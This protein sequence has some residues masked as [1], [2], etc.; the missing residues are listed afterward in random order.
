MMGHGGAAVVGATER[1]GRCWALVLCVLASALIGLLLAS[2]ASA[3]KVRLFEET[4]GSAAQPS[5]SIAE[6]LAVDPASGDLLVIDAGTSTLSR[7]NPDGTPANFSALGTNTI[8]GIGPGDETPQGGLG[9]GG[10]SEVQ[11]AVDDSGTATDGNI[12]LTQSFANVLDVFAPSGAY[13]GQLSAA[14]ATPFGFLC[15]VAVGPGGA[16]YVGDYSNGV[17]KFAP[18]ANPPLATDHTA[19]FTSVANPCAL[20]VGAGP[21]AGSLFATTYVGDVSKLDAT[22]GALQYVVS[23]GA[24]TTISLDPASGHLLAVQGQTVSEYDASGSEAL[25]VASF[26]A[27]REVL[28]LAIDGPSQDLYLARGGNP[29]L[30]TY[31]PVVTV[32]DASTAPAS[33]IGKTNATLN[34]TV[35]PDGV[36]LEECSF[37][38]GPT[39]AYGQSVPCAETVVEIG[40][41]SEALPVHA[42]LGG[43]G[44]G[45]VYH[46][47]LVARNANGTAHGAD[48]SFKTL[49]PPAIEEQWVHS[50]FLAEA[51]LKGS[52]NPEG[53]PTSFHIEYGTDTT[54]GQST[55]ESSLG[56]GKAA[57]GL[58]ATLQGLE[59]GT[60]YHWRVVATNEIGVAKG[61]DRTFV[62]YER[63]NPDTSCPNQ[64]FRVGV[65]ALLPNCRAY[66]MVSPVEKNNG[67]IITLSQI[68]EYRSALNQS[69][70]D[71]E[72]LTYSSYKAFGDAVGSHYSNQYI[73]SRGKEGWG[74]RSISPPHSHTVFQPGLAS[75]TWDLDVQF[76]AFTPDLSSAWLAD[77]AKPPL[78][79]DA[80]EGKVNL[81]RRENASGSYESLIKSPPSIAVSEKGYGMEIQGLTADGDHVL[82]AA[83][84]ALTPDAAPTANRQLYD[85]T[86]GELELVSVL[87]NG[88]PAPTPSNAGRVGASS[89][90]IGQRN[91]SLEHAISEDGSR[92]YFTTDPGFG[93]A[94]RIYVRIDAKTTVAVSDSVGVGTSAQF[95]AASADGSKAIF[96]VGALFTGEASLYEF[97]LAT[98]TPTLLTEQAYGLLGASDDASHLYFVSAEDLDA[99]ALA[100]E[101]NLYLRHEG[102]VAF[103]ATLSDADAAQGNLEPSNVN[104]EPINHTAKTTPDGRRIAF[105]SERSL[106]GYDNTDANNGKAATEVFHYDAETER[107]SCASCNPSGA[108][109]RGEELQRPYSFRA[110]KRW[111]AAWLSTAENQLYGVRAL[112]EDGGRLFFNSY[113]ALLPRDTNGAQDVYQWEAQGTGGCQ[114]VEG[115]LDLLSS[116]ESPTDSEFVD[117]SADGE[118]VFISTE[119]SLTPQDQG[120]ID[121]YA[122]RANGGFAPPPAPPTPCLGDA[123][124]S[125]PAPP[126]PPAPASARFEGAGDPPAPTSR[127][128][129]KARRGKAAKPR[130]QGK[131]RASRGCRRTTRRAGR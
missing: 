29:N 91:G 72:E 13:L 47:R 113:D 1:Q 97:D 22:T 11:V 36:A 64:A 59:E 78:T 45:S 46:F 84:A 107:L 63:P 61:A 35:N 130:R 26:T 43:L 20:A 18:S 23:A 125:V 103:I 49:S 117:A 10:P 76:K 98:Q 41:G 17:H 31:G 55:P 119:S 37:E 89:A 66:E 30:E 53:F 102:E 92:I 39:A 129:C 105:M 6:G 122:V 33:A 83:A 73:A 69:S 93:G 38:Y 2:P 3:A 27:P 81:F 86:G 101:P 71:G 118:N 56:S 50:V 7:F 79:T 15:G 90:L 14:G 28:G 80:V 106:T 5:F 114:R 100:G 95:L 8:D 120:L 108:R 70:T 87:P 127:R 51:L 25:Q 44:L 85:Y 99:G 12:Y 60:V 94:G 75:P 48:E 68:S 65:A 32:P 96:A 104:V 40:A 4:F 111:A 131:R 21:S 52:V 9:F 77:S 62:T 74:T 82:F 88:T 58:S 128:R 115:C 42:E 112:S 109:P 126:S 16:L 110:T 123:C 67:D 54:Y 19:T 24:N 116:G 34:G 124:Q 57:K 121:I